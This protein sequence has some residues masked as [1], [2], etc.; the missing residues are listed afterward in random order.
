MERSS[1]AQSHSNPRTKTAPRNRRGPRYSPYNHAPSPAEIADAAR[2]RRPLHLLRETLHGGVA[3][4]VRAVSRTGGTPIAHVLGPPVHAGPGKERSM[5]H[6]V[7]LL[8]SLL[9]LIYAGGCSDGDQSI[10]DSPGSNPTIAGGL[11]A[12]P[13]TPPSP[14]AP[15]NP[16]PPAP[17]SGP[18][19]PAPGSL[20]G[21]TQLAVP[22]KLAGFKQDPY[23]IA[24]YIDVTRYGAKG[25]GVTDDTAA[26]QQALIDASGNSA[27]LATGASMVVYVPPGKYLI[28]NTI[29]GYQ[30]CNSNGSLPNTGYYGGAPG[31]SAPSLVGSPYNRPTII[32]KDG[33]F[34]DANNPQPMIHMVN[35]PNGTPSSCGY[36]WWKTSAIGAFDILFNTVVRDINIT[37][38]NNPDAIG[39]QFYSAQMS[40]MQNV[41]IDANGGYIGIQGSPATEVWTNVAVNGGQYGVWIDQT[42]GAN[43]IAGLTLQNQSVAGVYYAAVGN[44][45]I[46]G[47]NIQESASSATGIVAKNLISQ[48]GT[49]SL[50]DGSISTAG[51]QPAV[52]NTGSLSLYFNNVY[53]NAPKSLVVNAGSSTLASNGTWQAIQEYAHADQSTN[54]Q[55]NPGYALSCVIVNNDKTQSSDYGPV[56][57]SGPV[58]NDLVLRHVPSQ[59]PWAFDP[60]TAWVTDFG[61]DPTAGTDSTAAIQAAV[62]SAHTA[63]S[64]EVFLPRGHYLISNTIKLFPNTKF[65]GIPGSYASLVGPNWDPGGKVLPYLQVGDSAKDPTGT[66]AGTAIV[67]D[68][69]FFLFTTGSAKASVDAQSHL[70]AIDWQTGQNS[71]LNQINVEFQYQQAWS[72]SSPP[73]RSLVSF[74]DTGGGRIYGLQIGG[75][76]G[77]NGPDGYSFAAV[78][79]SAPITMY[80]SNIEHAQGS[81][82][83][84]FIN[85]SNIRVLGSKT[86]GGQAKTW[87]S[88][89]GS[90]NILISG[91]ANHGSSPS[92]IKS[93]S[94]I[95]IN[96]TS[97]YAQTPTSNPY[98]TDSAAQYPFSQNYALFQLGHF[99]N[100]VFPSC[101]NGGCGG[102]QPTS[103]CH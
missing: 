15:P 83:Y 91:L 13:P 89:Q 48:G 42:A 45:S 18:A 29:T 86:E 33:T 8:V 55:S 26:F 87:F 60:S 76:W 88:I 41:S 49:V 81:S 14:C 102:G 51:S 99:D 77:Y 85:S 4:P 31:L 66:K 1:H 57:G 64:D 72:L 38:G 103:A 67:S 78:N 63:G 25:D 97:F 80:G 75:D 68:I 46:S 56:F 16:Q 94:N 61:A 30:A 20:S 21:A 11:P 37:T 93:S 90:Q 54:P 17:P 95:N 71:I 9:S 3:S 19:P 73:S 53:V 50:V 7:Q 59:M 27:S 2:D 70:T 69:G 35:T 100:S 65:F 10:G 58:P 34:K 92:S 98:V 47:F 24:G 96:T 22:S 12:T 36:Q 79:T 82:F 52:D 101:A 5:G 39:V 32:L 74:H 6:R 62:S 44:L 84:G 23:V 43:S 40:Y 28:S